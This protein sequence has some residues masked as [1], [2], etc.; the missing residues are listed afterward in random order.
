MKQVVISERVTFQQRTR[1]EIR[2][3]AGIW[4]KSRSGFL[5]LGNI[6]SWGEI[7]LC[8]REG[9]RVHCSM[10]AV[11]PSLYPLDTKSILPQAVTIKNVSRDTWLAESVECVT[12]DLRS[13][14]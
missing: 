9:Y 5:N 11:L 7:I 6:D 8:W 12:F 2:G 10:L 14:V 4:T 13:Y 1:G 3:H